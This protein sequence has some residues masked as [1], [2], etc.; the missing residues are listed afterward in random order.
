MTRM[1]DFRDKAANSWRIFVVTVFFLTPSFGFA[2]ALYSNVSTETQLAPSLLQKDMRNGAIIQFLYDDSDFRGL[3]VTCNDRSAMVFRGSRSFAGRPTFGGQDYDQ[4]WLNS[5]SPATGSTGIIFAD[6]N[7]DGLQDFYSPNP[8]GH[9]LYQCVQGPNG[10]GFKDVTSDMGLQF[11]T[12]A[13]FNKTINGSWGD[14]DGDSFVDLLLVQADLDRASGS[15]KLRLLHNDQGAG[16]SNLAQTWVSVYDLK[17]RLVKRLHDSV[18]SEG[19][20]TVHWDGKQSNGRNVSSGLYFVQ[21]SSGEF[22]STIS[23]TLTK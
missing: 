13:D 7:N 16:F 14:Y 11:T 22:C 9:Q 10:T 1:K 20:H 17:G 3:I 6:F 23:V 12:L 18:L 4:I 15:Q 5:S 19:A 8:S 2:T 21:V